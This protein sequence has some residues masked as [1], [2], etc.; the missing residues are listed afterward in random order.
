MKKKS[1]KKFRIKGLLL[2]LLIVYL[3]G[4]VI[5]L[6]M[7]TPCHNLVIKGLDL[8]S[9]KEIM[10]ISKINSDTSITKIFTSNICKKIKKLDFVDTCK[11]SYSFPLKV[12]ITIEENKILF[13]DYLNKKYVLSNG[14][15]IEDNNYIGYPILI[16]YTPSDILENFIEGL[17]KVDQDI[18]KMISE[19]EYSP[20]RYNETIIDEDRFL[21]RMNDGNEVFINTVNIEKLNNYQSIYATIE[22]KGVLYL[23]SN[24][25]TFI[26]KK[27]G[28]VNEE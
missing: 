9:E 16:N 8:L 19:I 1:K 6:I 13:Y 10:D 12:T 26:F 25:K 15:S 11:V 24:S 5:Y 22:E 20:D 21:L 4:M 2:I 27:Y 18:I 14:K 17:N 7:S 28:E 3:L 23:D